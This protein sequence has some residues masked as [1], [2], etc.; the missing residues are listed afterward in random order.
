MN[1]I[2]IQKPTYLPWLTDKINK[3]TKKKNQ[4]DK[5]I[6]KLLNALN[7]EPEFWNFYNFVIEYCNIDNLT[8][9]KKEYCFHKMVVE[10][11]IKQNDVSIL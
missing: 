10:N 8:D 2:K 3:C 5:D 7:R 6:D 1:T 9:S 4:N 11:W